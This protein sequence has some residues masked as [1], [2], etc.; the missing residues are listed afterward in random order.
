M[1]SY[2][3]L[4]KEQAETKLRHSDKERRAFLVGTFGKNRIDNFHFDIELWMDR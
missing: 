1:M 4:T 3:H 2:E